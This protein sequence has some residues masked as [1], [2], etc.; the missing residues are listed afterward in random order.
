MH[1][2][3]SYGKGWCTVKM[4]FHLELEDAPSKRVKKMMKGCVGSSEDKLKL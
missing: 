3:W 2:K 1:R 4:N